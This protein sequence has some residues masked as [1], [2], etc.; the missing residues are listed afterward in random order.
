M[1]PNANG[2]GRGYGD[3]PSSSG[4]GIVHW[5]E[6]TLASLWESAFGDPTEAFIP[7]G[8]LEMLESLGKVFPSHHLLLADFDLLPGR[9][10]DAINAPVVAQKIADDPNRRGHTRDMDTY[11]VE[12]G[13]ADIFFPTDFNLLKHM[14]IEIM[15]SLGRDVKLADII[16]HGRFFDNYLKS[17][18][19]T[20]ASGEDPLKLDYTNMQ[21]FLASSAPQTPK[22]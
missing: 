19:T 20:L 2:G 11:L 1:N 3:I 21:I 18:A 14:Y 13:T 16:H 4:E 9:V 8:C 17:N 15:H 10:S 7:S 6:D 5:A 12:Q 22:S